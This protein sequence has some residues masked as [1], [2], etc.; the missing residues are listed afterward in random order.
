MNQRC[1]SLYIW[2]QY[3]I[4]VGSHF[5]VQRIRPLALPSLR[6]SQRIAITPQGDY[7]VPVLRVSAA[8]GNPARE[9]R[10][11]RYLEEWNHEQVKQ[12]FTG[13]NEARGSSR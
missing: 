2:R 9:S 5:S 4:P 11:L 3:E 12:T 1:P 8:V 6:V 7:I 13:S 10:M